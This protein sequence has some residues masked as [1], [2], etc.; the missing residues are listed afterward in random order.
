MP[1]IEPNIADTDITDDQAR[2]AIAILETKFFKRWV[3]DQEKN[4]SERGFIAGN[5]NVDDLVT[6]FRWARGQ[7][8]EEPSDA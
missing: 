7:L 8:K 6:V 5:V 2:E 4:G 1:K 3:R